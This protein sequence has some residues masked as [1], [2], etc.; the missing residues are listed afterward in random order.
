MENWRVVPVNNVKF[1]VL[2]KI[3]EAKLKKKNPIGSKGKANS[4]LTNKPKS[5]Q[6]WRFDD[7][8]SLSIFDT[9]NTFI[10]KV[11]RENVNS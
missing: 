8:S 7:K 2:G 4:D 11:K 3:N 10:H 5:K 1:D 6:K 9:S